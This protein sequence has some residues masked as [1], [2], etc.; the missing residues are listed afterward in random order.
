[1]KLLTKADTIFNRTMNLFIIV[2]AAL[3]IFLM[4]AIGA[5]VV[6]RYFLNR[7]IV[8]VL[9]I[10][11]YILLY[12]T[13]LVTAWVLK[14]EGHVR[15]DL[16]V[17]RLNQKTQVF[18]GIFSSIIGIIISLVLMWYGTAIVYEHFQRGEFYHGTMLELQ[19]AP[20]LII[21]PIGSFLLLIQFLKR[22]LGFFMRW[23]ASC[24]E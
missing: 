8:W 7:P 4:L 24:A 17:S 22:T 9:E 11:T 2:A 10:S 14:E 12:I 16:V 1:M 15:T 13:F 23:K 6:M 21:I 19:T 3:L 18:L 20:I 5:D